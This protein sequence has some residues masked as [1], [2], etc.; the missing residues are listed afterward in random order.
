[1]PL[2]KSGLTHLSFTVNYLMLVR[3]RRI[4]NPVLVINKPGIS[5]H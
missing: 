4:L 2:S 5:H 1:M 3:V